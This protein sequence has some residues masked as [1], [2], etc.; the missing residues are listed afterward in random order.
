VSTITLLVKNGPLT[1][2]DIAMIRRFA[3]ERSFDLAFYPG[4]R[5]DE[6]N[7]YNLLDEPYFFDGAAA[8]IGLERRA[9]LQ[10]YKF[11]IAPTTDDRPFF[12]KWRALPELLQR[13][14]MGGAALLDWGYPILV[15]TLAQA[16]ALGLVL[17]LMPL[18]FSGGRP[19]AAAQAGRVALYFLAIGFAFLFIEIASIQRFILFLS[20][21]LNAIAVVLCA[22]L[23]FAGI[24]SG[25]APRLEARLAVWRKADRHVGTSTRSRV[26]R[27]RFAI[28]DALPVVIAAITF[29]VVLHLLLLPPL[30]RWLMPLPEPI[31][32]VV[33]LALIAP[34]AVWMGMPFP[35]MLSRIA[36][37]TPDLVPWAWSINGCASVVSAVAASLLA[38]NIGFAGVVMTAIDFYVLPARRVRR[39]GAPTSATEDNDAR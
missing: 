5:R 27:L 18:W 29:V 19:A 9:F 2:D 17:I 10:R 31:K 21:P 11:D 1:E 8:L 25:L 30:F 28:P 33:S 14:T 6:A 22:F 38:M 7:R 20:H 3:D 23:V 24:G 12:F 32:I 16:A 15:A 35:L 39:H 34:L 4:M 13:P 26:F 37:Q 36:A